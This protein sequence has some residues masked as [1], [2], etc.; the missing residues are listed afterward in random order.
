MWQKLH[1]L[2][3]A[4]SENEAIGKIAGRNTP[5]LLTFFFSVVTGELVEFGSCIH[6]DGI[7]AMLPELCIGKGLEQTLPSKGKINKNTPKIQT[8]T[9]QQYLGSYEI[10]EHDEHHRL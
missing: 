10:A 2:I 6:A 5:R 4:P 7:D 8:N 1:C 9:Y 3:I